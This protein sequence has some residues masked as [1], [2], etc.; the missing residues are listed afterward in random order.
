M[1]LI[2]QTERLTLTPLAD[3]D[4]DLAIELFTDP[5][6]TKYV[7][8]LMSNADIRGEFPRWKR[9]GAD[10]QFGIWC[11]ADRAS[12]EKCGTG[13][14]LPMPIDV[15]DTKWEMLVPGVVPD[16]EIEVGY[17]LKRSAWGRGLATEICTRLLRFAFEQTSLDEVVATFD[18]PN[19][20]S[21]RVLLKCGLRD[22][23]TRRAYAEDAAPDFR[24]TRD[25][26]AALDTYGQDRGG[27]R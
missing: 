4:I 3:G 22:H 11:V 16:A 19:T 25:E 1:N 20:V 9:R 24:I 26:W 18:D 7:G 12:G 21:R 13:A 6:V 15:D 27:R 2:L 17:I 14:L 8:E 10:G 5:E 23:G